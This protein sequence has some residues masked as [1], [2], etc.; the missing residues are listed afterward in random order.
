MEKFSLKNKILM[1]VTLFSMFFG[2]GN[3]IFPPFLGAQ[4]GT[5]TW[6]AFLG[7]AISAVGLPI[8]GVIAVTKSG[9]LE[10]LAS[11]VH[12]KFSFVYIMI[13]YLAIGPCLAIPRTASTSFSMAVVPF[14]P[15][16]VSAAIPQ[17]L[18]SL[19]FF[20]AATAVA[21][22]PEKLTEY[23]GKRLTPILLVLIVV[24]FAAGVIMAAGG[25]GIL[26][27]SGAEPAELYVKGVAVQGFLDGYQT[28]DTLAALN[29]GMIVA[30]NIQAK[31]IKK[32]K[33]V[34][35]ETIS[36]GWIAGALLLTVY[37]MLTY[38]GK[39]SGITFAGAA[40][41]T[42]VLVDMA[43][44]L[45]GRMGTIILGVIFVIACFNTCVGL[46]SCCGKYFTE[47][48]PK[49]SYRGWVF[50]FA[51]VSMVL[52]NVG[53]DMIL[54]YSVPV[55]NAIY[56]M[57]ILLII[58]ALV[59]RWTGRFRSIYPWTAALCGISSILIVLDQNGILIP[60]ITRLIKML[61]AYEA[62]FGWIMPTLAGA[63]AGILIDFTKKQ[64][65]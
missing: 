33:A 49:I 61:P 15:E 3:L 41:G 14:M 60:G 19:V 46:F 31:G 43:D 40:N 25:N 45:F 21:M 35:K 23:L 65:V 64:T 18:Y 51:F 62:G 13:L 2:A 56:P 34:I 26:D 7:F 50:V 16:G 28:M 8:L 12:P 27:A 44:I 4:A 9:G 42:A 32:E 47:I 52:S 24:L 57:A 22:H 20:A 63:A 48:F 1:G 17:L 59:Y 11:R 38:V 37:G 58:L 53:L 54:Q 55:L 5:H 36:A 29:F 39:I 10:H 6:I 30:L